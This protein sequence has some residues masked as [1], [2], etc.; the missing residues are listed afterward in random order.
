MNKVILGIDI[1]T[2]SCKVIAFNENL[3]ILGETSNKYET[4]FPDNYKFE[5]NPDDWWNATVGSLK[6]LIIDANNIIRIIY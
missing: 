4:I 5:Q 3:K 2:S 6:K 1:G